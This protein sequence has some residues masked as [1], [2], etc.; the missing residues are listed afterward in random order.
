METKLSQ[1]VQHDSQI[2]LQCLPRVGRYRAYQGT[3]WQPHPSER[4]TSSS[5]RSP[6]RSWSPRCRRTVRTPG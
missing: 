5:G 3:V 6:R 4:L 1:T 2:L